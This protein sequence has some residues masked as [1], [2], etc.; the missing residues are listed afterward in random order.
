MLSKVVVL[1]YIVA[2]AAK[3]SDASSSVDV[4]KLMKTI[5]SRATHRPDH[6]RALHY[7]SEFKG[8]TYLIGEIFGSDSTCGAGSAN[9][10][11]FAVPVKH[12]YRDDCFTTS[13]FVAPWTLHNGFS[14]KVTKCAIDSDADE[15]GDIL[16][17]TNSHYSSDCSGEVSFNFWYSMMDDHG[18]VVKHDQCAFLNGVYTKLKCT[19]HYSFK[20]LEGYLKKEFDDATDCKS[21]TNPEL[22]HRFKPGYCKHGVTNHGP[23]IH[24]LRLKE[25]VGKDLV[26][27]G[28]GDSNCV[29]SMVDTINQP[30]TP[31]DAGKCDSDMENERCLRVFEPPTNDGDRYE[32]CFSEFTCDFVNWQ[33]IVSVETFANAD[34]CGDKCPDSCVDACNGVNLPYFSYDGSEGPFI[35]YCAPCNAV[36][37]LPDGYLGNMYKI[38]GN[39]CP[40][41]PQVL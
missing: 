23:D 16:I 6:G 35:C 20:G 40:A 9:N 18:N 10:V 31:Y 27:E 13:G 36:T 25:C 1:G 22:F 2:A 39:E 5:E 29:G 26:W 8:S 37:P 11:E 33:D 7:T 30:L 24:S 21:N 38:K 15:M 34:T 17:E 14:E 28:F 19:P 12:W 3:V 41:K 32:W 4:E